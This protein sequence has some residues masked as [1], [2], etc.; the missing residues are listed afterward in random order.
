LTSCILGAA[1]AMIRDRLLARES[2]GRAFAESEIRRTLDALLVGLAPD[3]RTR[4][5]ARSRIGTR[6]AKR[7]K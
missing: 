7:P 4:V 1:E 3:V 2:G 6:A 5:A